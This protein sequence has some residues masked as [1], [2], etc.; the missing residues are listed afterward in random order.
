MSLGAVRGLFTWGEGERGREW[1]E[2]NCGQRYILQGTPTGC[3]DR[4]LLRFPGGGRGVLAFSCCWLRHYLRPFTRRRETS[5]VFFGAFTAH[6]LFLDVSRFQTL[7]IH[8][9]RNEPL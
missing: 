2:A 5:W 4:V 8:L 9:K 7:L 6:N 1:V 3:F